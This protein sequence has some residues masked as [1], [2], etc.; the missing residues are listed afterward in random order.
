VPGSITQQPGS[1]VPGSIAQQPGSLAQRPGS[2]AP[3]SPGHPAHPGGLV[4]IPTP[5]GI[6]PSASDRQ[7][8]APG[9]GL[10]LPA[11][12]AH[13]HVAPRA[14]KLIRARAEVVISGQAAPGTRLQVGGQAVA[15]GADG[16]F[17]LRVPVGEGMADLAIEASTPSGAAAEHVHLWFGRLTQQG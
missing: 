4:P 9:T 11:S 3:G 17:S 13:P 1:Q 7:V 10:P 6:M 12:E 8:G 2:Q 16:T 5:G 14:P 15:V